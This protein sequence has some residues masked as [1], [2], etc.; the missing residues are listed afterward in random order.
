[1]KSSMKVSVK[2]SHWNKRL[3]TYLLKFLWNVHSSKMS[4]NFR[5]LDAHDGPMWWTI[6]S[7]DVGSCRLESRLLLDSFV[8]YLLTLIDPSAVIGWDMS[9]ENPWVRTTNTTPRPIVQS[10]DCK[11]PVL[12]SGVSPEFG[13]ALGFAHFSHTRPITCHILR[14]SVA[15]QVV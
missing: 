14:G 8:A 4:W 13:L 5:S 10:Q 15:P 9:R 1:M 6:M 7:D 3:F 2:M 11:I 12:S